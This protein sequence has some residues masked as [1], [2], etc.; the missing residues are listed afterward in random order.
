MNPSDTWDTFIK[1]NSSADSEP[2]QRALV[3]VVL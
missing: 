3:S 1:A 2:A